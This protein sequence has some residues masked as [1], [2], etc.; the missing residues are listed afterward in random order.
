MA[1]MM[2]L[3]TEVAAT[4]YCRNG[5]PWTQAIEKTDA[6]ES[7]VAHCP[8][9]GQRAVRFTGEMATNFKTKYPEG[10]RFAGEL[11]VVQFVG[12]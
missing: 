3:I 12:D 11:P 7:F 1:E 10:L 6:Q 4:L 5:H 2:V 9:C 8:Y